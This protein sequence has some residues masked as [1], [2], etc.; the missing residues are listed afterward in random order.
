MLGLIGKKVGMTQVFDERGV[1]TP[2][3]VIKIDGNI[4]VAE[5]TVEKNGYS[6]CVIGAEEV[7]ESRVSK[8]YAGQFKAVEGPKKY[9]FEMKDFEKEV[10]VGDTLGVDLFKEISFVDVEGTTKGKGF[11]GVMKRHG[12]SG[13]WSTHGSKFHRGL[14]GTGMAATPSRIFKGKKMPG[15]MGGEAATVQNLRVVKVDEDK[16][17][18]MVKGAVPGPRQSVVVVKKAK[19]K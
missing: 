13:G 19:K 4:V 17:V 10:T 11:Q 12:F 8:P 2:V 1:L 16:N 9:L 5:R 7:K 15:R 6:A 18:L 14:G 3:T